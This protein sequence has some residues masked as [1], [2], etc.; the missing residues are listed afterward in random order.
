MKAALFDRRTLY[1]KRTGRLKL[2]PSTDRRRGGRIGRSI[3]SGDGVVPMP[4]AVVSWQS[5][6]SLDDPSGRE[7]GKRPV[8]KRGLVL[9]TINTLTNMN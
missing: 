7:R 8:R 2:T 9:F 5:L 6:G 3:Y 4:V 1:E